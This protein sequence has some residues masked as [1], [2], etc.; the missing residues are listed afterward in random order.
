M[1]GFEE[2]G[3]ELCGLDCALLVVLGEADDDGA[4]TGTYSF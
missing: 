1:V 4:S 2:R 3:G